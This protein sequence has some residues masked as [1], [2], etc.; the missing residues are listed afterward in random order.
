MNNVAGVYQ[1]RNT[2]NGKMYVAS[3]THCFDDWCWQR[4][5]ARKGRHR[6]RELQAD[7]IAY[8][9]EKFIFEIVAEEADPVKRSQVKREAI[10]E[11]RAAGKCY[12][13]SL[14]DAI[15]EHAAN[16]KSRGLRGDLERIMMGL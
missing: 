2:I 5:S 13:K 1:I 14:S 16:R 11:A 3:A 12:N 4:H 9:E 6:S 7:W 8:G 10:A 15:R